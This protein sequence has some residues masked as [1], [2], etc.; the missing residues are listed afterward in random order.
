MFNKPGKPPGTPKPLERSREPRNSQ[1]NSDFSVLNRPRDPEPQI[2]KFAIV[3]CFENTT[4]KIQNMAGAADLGTS[5]G[6][7]SAERDPSTGPE[8]FSAPNTCSTSPEGFSATGT[9]PEGFSAECDP[10]TSP[11]GF[12]APNACS[13]SPEGFSATGTSPGGFSA[14]CVPSTSPEG[15]FRGWVRLEGG[16]ESRVRGI[17]GSRIRGSRGRE[18]DGWKVR[19]PGSSRDRGLRVAHSLRKIPQVAS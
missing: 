17:E 6:G 11:E 16:E 1:R 13:T 4:Q 9:S 18:I 14:E 10:S 12:S 19:G 3:S 2:L 5:P 15:G 7:F 8:G